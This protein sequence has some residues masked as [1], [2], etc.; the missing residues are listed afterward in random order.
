METK[1]I[2]KVQGISLDERDTRD[3]LNERILNVT[4]RLSNNCNFTCKYCS[5][6]DNKVKPIPVKELIS[7]LYKFIESISFSGKYDKINWYI[8]GGEPTIY[9]RF[10]ETMLHI[11]ACHD[12]FNL[13]YEIEVQ[14]NSSY[15]KYEHFAVLRNVKISFICS[16]QNHQ[17]TKDQFLNFVSFMAEH[18]MLAGIDLIL[19]N[20]G[21]ENEFENIEYIFN[22]LRQL[23]ETNNHY[24][25]IQTNTIDGVS[26]DS[27]DSRYKTFA[28]NK[29]YSEL[30]EIEYTDGT[31]EIE[32]FDTFTSEGRNKF[33]LFKCNV[34]QNS[35]IIDTTDDLTIKVY[36]CFSDILYQKNKP[37]IKFIFNE[38]SLALDIGNIKKLLKPTI[39]IH[40]KC[41]CELQIPKQKLPKRI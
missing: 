28:L 36:K 25:N 32:D 30:L 12:L 2:Y 9:P 6:Y 17:N 22:E 15:K 37:D 41:I 33:K 14:T 31:K 34:G 24:F 1:Q 21:T 8:H 11:G 4:L 10:L 19:E 5:Y 3:F 16:Y 38:E 40:P 27:I 7:F 35:L 18:N 13:D 20:F 29:E 23:R 26:L 39:C